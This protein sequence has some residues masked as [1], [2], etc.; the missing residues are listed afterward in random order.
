[1]P[2]FQTYVETNGSTH[3]TVVYN[4]TDLRVDPDYLYYYI[5][6]TRY[7]TVGHNK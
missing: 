6:W 5:H 3:V 2:S 7:G 1:V 4:A